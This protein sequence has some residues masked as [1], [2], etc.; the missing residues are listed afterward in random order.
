MK[1]KKKFYG[2]K[3]G[4]TEIG[5]STQTIDDGMESLKKG[6]KRLKKALVGDLS[7]KKT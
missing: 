5:L 2:V 6:S 3:L 1:N 4:E 7:D